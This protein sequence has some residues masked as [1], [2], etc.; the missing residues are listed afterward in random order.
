MKLFYSFLLVIITLK[1]FSCVDTPPVLKKEAPISAD[2]FFLQHHPYDY[3]FRSSKTSSPIDF[4]R[5]LTDTAQKVLHDDG[6][7]SPMPFVHSVGA[8][9]TGW[10]TKPYMDTLMS[11][12]YSRR[13]C[14]CYVN[15][16]S[17]FLPFKDSADIGGFVIEMAKAYK[18]QRPLN[19]G[20]WACPRSNQA[21]AD[22]LTEWWTEK[23]QLDSI[24]QLYKQSQ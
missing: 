4:I 20:L 17:S 7:T 1:L 2:S 19:L 24:K 21:E 9:P 16:A 14:K 18:Y 10:I 5:A 13:K 23:Q 12:L 6:T 8:F 22:Q 11:L 15:S 3:R